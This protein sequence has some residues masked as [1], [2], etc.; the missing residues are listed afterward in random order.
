MG[1]VGNSAV[2]IAVKCHAALEPLIL[3]GANHNVGNY[4][5]RR[6]LQRLS[7]M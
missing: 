7:K 2:E 5:T 4:I 3:G 1:T 6:E